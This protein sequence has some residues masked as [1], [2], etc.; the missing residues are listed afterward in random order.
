MLQPIYR[1][2]NL[3]KYYVVCMYIMTFINIQYWI[4]QYCKIMALNL[5]GRP[6]CY[7]FLLGK[8]KTMD[9]CR[10]LFCVCVTLLLFRLIDNII[11]EILYKC[12]PNQTTS[13]HFIFPVG[14]LLHTYRQKSRCRVWCSP[15][16]D[17]VH[18]N[19]IGKDS[20]TKSWYSNFRSQ[21][22]K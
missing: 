1:V 10:H 11:M 16:F 18:C 5:W 19:Y 20:S 15:I 6:F 9:L 17:F 14:L 12:C 2:V 8:T 7:Y 21:H 13:H 22:I 4:L 3:Y